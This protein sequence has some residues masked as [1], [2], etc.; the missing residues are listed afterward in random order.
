[1]DSLMKFLKS[2]KSTQVGFN[3]SVSEG[4]R[5]ESYFVLP[6]C[7]PEN[8]EVLEKV[9]QIQDSEEM[10]PAPVDP[11]AQATWK[12]LDEFLKRLD[13]E[14][15][16]I[17]LQWEVGPA[18]TRAPSP[19]FEEMY[20]Y[21]LITSNG[22]WRQLLGMHD[23]S[24]EPAYDMAQVD[25][26][27][28]QHLEDSEHQQLFDRS[29]FPDGTDSYVPEK[30]QAPIRSVSQP[31]PLYLPTIQSKPPPALQLPTAL[32]PFHSDWSNLA[33]TFSSKIS[34]KI[35]PALAK[36]Q[37]YS[38][39]EQH[40]PTIKEQ[41]SSIF[42]AYPHSQR[43][44]RKRYSSPEPDETSKRWYQLR[45]KSAQVK[46]TFNDDDEEDEENYSWS[47]RS[48]EKSWSCDEEDEDEDEDE[49][50]AVE[51]NEDDLSENEEEF[52]NC[53]KRKPRPTR[54]RSSVKLCDTVRDGS[55]EYPTKNARPPLQTLSS[56]R[57]EKPPCNPT[58][59]SPD[60][61][62]TVDC[63]PGPLKPPDPIRTSST[64]PL[65]S[66]GEA[67]RY[68]GG[69]GM[70]LC[71]SS[72]NNMINKHVAN[73]PSVPSSS[74]EVRQ[75]SGA[76]S[77]S[78][79][80]ANTNNL[81]NVFLS[82]S[83]PATAFVLP[84]P[85]LQQPANTLILLPS[86]TNSSLLMLTLPSP[87]RNV[88]GSATS[89]NNNGTNQPTASLLTTS[90]PV[91]AQTLTL[92]N[93]DS[94]RVN[95]AF[96]PVNSSAIS[97][98]G[99][100]VQG[101]ASSL[102][103]PG[104]GD[105]NTLLM[106]QNFSQ[107]KTSRSSVQTLPSLT[108][109]YSSPRSKDNHL[110]K[111]PL[112][113]LSQLVS[114]LSAKNAIMP[115][116]S[117]KNNRAKRKDQPG[118]I[119]LPLFQSSVPIKE[120]VC[121]DNTPTVSSNHAEQN[122]HLNN[123]K[124]T[125]PL[126][127]SLCEDEQT[128]PMNQTSQQ[129]NCPT[130]NNLMTPLEVD[131]SESLQHLTPL[132]KEEQN[133]PS[134]TPELHNHCTPNLMQPSPPP[135]PIN[136][137]MRTSIITAPL[138][139]SKEQNQPSNTP[140]LHNHCTPNLMQPSPPP[141]PIND[142]MRTSIITAPLPS[143]VQSNN[144]TSEPHTISS[145][146]LPASGSL[147]EQPLPLN[148]PPRLFCDP[149]KTA[150]VLHHPLTPPPDF[151]ATQIVTD[152]KLSTQILLPSFSSENKDKPPCGAASGL[153]NSLE[154]SD[155]ASANQSP[156]LSPSALPLPKSSLPSNATTPVQKQKLNVDS[157][158]NQ[159]GGKGVP[160]VPSVSVVLQKMPTNVLAPFLNKKKKTSNKNEAI[161]QASISL[162]VSPLAE[163]NNEKS[164]SSRNRKRTRNGYSLRTDQKKVNYTFEE[165][166]DEDDA[167]S[168][169][170]G[171]S[172]GWRSGSSGME[173]DASV[174]D[175]EVVS[176]AEEEEMS[177]IPEEHGKTS[178]RQSKVGSKAANK[179]SS[180]G[181]RKIYQCKHCPYT[182]NYYSNVKKHTHKHTGERPYLCPV[183]GKDFM[184]PSA[185]R[186]HQKTHSSVPEY[187]CT[188]CEKEFYT[189]P[190]LKLH[191]RSHDGLRPFSCTECEK[192][193]A[194]RGSLQ[195]HM[196]KHSP[197]DKEKTF[198]CTECN[199][200]FFLSR[201]LKTHLRRHASYKC[202]KCEAVF[203][204]KSMLTFHQ[205]SHNVTQTCEKCL[206]EFQGD[207]FCSIYK[208]D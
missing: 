119:P 184:D 11:E 122:S 141:S 199:K 70:T 193:Y 91:L 120:Q 207:H 153:F 108:V 87:Q 111:S 92:Q 64:S 54:S 162:T 103:L 20:T 41:E 82:I 155:L 185:R 57:T 24:E 189:G 173:S 170:S 113:Y 144:H 138:P 23:L 40:Q 6:K 194:N 71:R 26:E 182:S 160:Q 49:E 10:V 205:L 27:A 4:P 32:S 18:E 151:S 95:K 130:S 22:S 13:N 169:G 123:S 8:V 79:P 72:A 73:D 107:I 176:E 133:Q 174:S 42:P 201:M 48:S 197:N 179:N 83:Q 186:L 98:Q 65:L 154:N 45:E 121:P 2:I 36:T 149:Q 62:V 25:K 17:M 30:P 171:S 115:V 38:V 172:H 88:P 81:G 117:R 206:E 52:Q 106:S 47:D 158:D 126:P 181:A 16:G 190:S 152:I 101:M 195:E 96:Q 97:N 85:Q 14:I 99:G 127:L 164:S 67:Q 134:N 51:M 129:K 9:S 75:N 19:D 104:S 34:Q 58:A 175:E 29:Q 33:K 31:S 135:S 165:A 196:F 139:L 161:L 128:L 187:K 202:D 188:K 68:N 21:P 63:V 59:P 157:L 89:Q 50:N 46:Y 94:E 66:K 80:N 60:E 3:N 192:S 15:E 148:T 159:L 178:S 136:D 116:L 177:P 200:S 142:Q 7:E 74:K 102:L 78:L 132:S 143:H 198:A 150:Q 77:H 105:T 84:A 37:T 55:L 140:E 114:S 1:M 69:A 90:S 145:P 191:L 163:E 180:R 44:C 76:E 118:N 112:F 28:L 203:I 125:P 35:N 5:R 100:N 168:K 183:C 93:A 208:D 86:G 39:A 43:P 53:A 167:C 166:S 12:A 109:S 156:A 131:S 137:Q 147:S 124:E 61:A 110:A 204:R 56:S 146:W